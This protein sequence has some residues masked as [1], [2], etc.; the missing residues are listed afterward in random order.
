MGAR[1]G[2]EAGRSLVHISPALSALTLRCG[3]TAIRAIPIKNTP[4]DRNLALS[5][6]G[7]LNVDDNFPGSFTI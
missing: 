1:A 3:K 4:L 7:V 6:G 2:A 5:R